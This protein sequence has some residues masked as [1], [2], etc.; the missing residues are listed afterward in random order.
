M[1]SSGTRGWPVLEHFLV[2][3]LEGLDDSATAIRRD[4]VHAMQQKT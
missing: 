2:L 4:G 3:I 1:V